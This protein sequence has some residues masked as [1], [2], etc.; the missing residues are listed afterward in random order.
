MSW[1]RSTALF[2]HEARVIRS[3]IGSLITLI[4][5]PI[6]F[7]A[8][9]RPLSRLSLAGRFPDANGSEFAVP[10]MSTMFAFFLLSYGGFAFFSEHRQNTWERLRASPATNLEIIVG[11]VAPMLVMCLIQQA[12]LFAVGVVV[13]G[14]RVRGS[15]VG[16]VAIVVA[17]ALCLSAG[18]VMCAAILRTEQQLNS[19]TNLGTIVLSGIGG[20]IVPLAVLP[21]W[22]RVIA[23]LAPQYWAMRGYRAVILEPGGAAEV[24]VPAGALLAFGAAAAAIAL[25]RFRFDEPKVVRV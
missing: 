9:F 14:L 17:L 25:L 24:I 15:V 8:F 19:V 2:R 16:V 18:G 6:V 21:G 20:V 22:A 1:S 11:K 12:I 10:A 13:F 4:L 7:M 5:M 3:D 23:P